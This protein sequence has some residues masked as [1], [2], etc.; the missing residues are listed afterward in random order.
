MVNPLRRFRVAG[1]LL[2]V[3]VAYG[4][5]G[6]MLVEHWSLGDA[7]YMVVITI[8]TVGYGEVHPLSPAGRLFT[9]TL[10]VGGVATMLY[11]FGIFAELVGE[12]HIA[13]YR[14][15]RQMQRRVADLK[16]HFI[17]CGYGRIGTQIVTEFDAANARYIVIDNN[18][19]AVA[20][21]VHEDRLHLAGDAASEELLKEARID[22]ARGLICAVD[23]DERAVYI[24]LAARALKPDLYILARAGQPP[25]IRRLELAGADRVVSPYRMAGHQ[26]AGLALRP[27]LVEIMDTLQHGASAVGVEELLIRD[28]S[29]LAGKTLA[30][31]GLTQAALARLLAVRRRDGTLHVNPDD[32][33]KLAEG[34]LIVALGS[35]EQLAHTA[36]LLG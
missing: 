5:A 21:L 2:A 26:M 19:E 29:R 31:A 25:S 22:R 9:S 1:A 10:I 17:V 28:G 12:G 27:G 34:D 6:Y 24:V 35:D 4:V 7:L 3:I 8:S 13:E 32:E 30:E 15:Q 20:R 16:D 18:P 14:R 11:A 33:L 36:S 23:S